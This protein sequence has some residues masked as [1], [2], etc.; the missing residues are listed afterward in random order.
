MN[1]QSFPISGRQGSQ[2]IALGLAG[3][4]IV[5]M[6]TAYLIHLV[7]RSLLSAKT[8][9]VS[10]LVGGSQNSEPRLLTQAEW[11]GYSSTRSG[12][13]QMQQS[14]TPHSHLGC[15]CNSS[16]KRDTSNG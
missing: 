16:K 10:T 11:L 15:W 12:A 14:N 4:M 9:N 1:G 13:L 3:A 6:S 8:I 2:L 5:G 7:R